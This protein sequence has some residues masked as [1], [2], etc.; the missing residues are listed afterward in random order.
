MG[1]VYLLLFG[2]G[3]NPSWEIILG[4]KELDMTTGINEEFGP[5]V[6]ALPSYPNVRQDGETDRVHKSL[7]LLAI[8][9]AKRST[10]FKE[11][12]N[13]DLGYQLEHWG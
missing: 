10:V 3:K 1:L 7:T 12:L 8:V 9:R 2:R 13:R 5:R 6:A 4:L 11:H